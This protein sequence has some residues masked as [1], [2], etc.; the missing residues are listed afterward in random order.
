[1]SLDG[2]LGGG[3]DDHPGRPSP[4]DQVAERLGQ[5]GPLVLRSAAD[6]EGELVDGDDVEAELTAWRDLAQTRARS[7]E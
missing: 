7:T 5:L 2:L 6:V 4:R 3:D 1:M